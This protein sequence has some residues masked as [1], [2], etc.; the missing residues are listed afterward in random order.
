MT[1]RCSHSSDPSIR[2]N[3]QS[4]NIAALDQFSAL[5]FVD[6]AGLDQCARRRTHRLRSIGKQSTV[7]SSAL[8]RVITAN[9]RRL[10]INTQYEE[11]RQQSRYDRSL[12]MFLETLLRPMHSAPQPP[13]G[14]H[15]S[16]DRSTRMPLRSAREKEKKKRRIRRIIDYLLFTHTQKLMAACSDSRS[17]TNSK[18]AP[19]RSLSIL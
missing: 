19:L 15:G 1:C 8:S 10:G 5:S 14:L 7:V 9:V 16:Y 13:K 6:H 2:R 11:E 17:R 12:R 4:E 18:H 3:R